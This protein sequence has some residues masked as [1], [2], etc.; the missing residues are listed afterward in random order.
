MT[1]PT[2]EQQRVDVLLR[3]DAFIGSLQAISVNTVPLEEARAAVA[4]LIEAA[5]GMEKAV[6][7][8]T[9]HLKA[10]AFRDISECDKHRAFENR[11]VEATDRLRAALANVVS[12]P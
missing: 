11:V 6:R 9:D 12:Q 1:S 3:M 10:S 2:N 4:D 5:R 8:E 7:E